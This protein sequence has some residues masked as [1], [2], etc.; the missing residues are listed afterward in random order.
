LSEIR[1]SDIPGNSSI[2]DILKKFIKNA[3]EFQGD[4]PEK[5]YN[6]ILIEKARKKNR[7]IEFQVMGT[8]VRQDTLAC[9]STCLLT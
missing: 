1:K 5:Y 9:T 4:D 7:G 6:I 3:L 2:N 8:D